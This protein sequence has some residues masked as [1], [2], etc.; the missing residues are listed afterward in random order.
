MHRELKTIAK[1]VATLRRQGRLLQKISGVNDIY[2]FFQECPKRTS[3]DFLSFYVLNYIYQYIVKDEVAKRKT[4]ARVFEDLIA[5]L[6]GGVITDELQRKNEPDTVPILLEKHSQKLSGNKREKADVSFDNFSISIKT[7]MLDNSEINLGSFERKILFEGFGVDEYLKERK[8]TNG[9]GIGL[10]SKAQIRKLLHC[11]QEKGE[12]DQFARRF[13]VMFEYVFSDDL[14]IAIKEPNK[15]SLYFV[16]SVEFINLIKNKISNIDDFLEIVNRWEGNSI[17]VDRRK[18][19][20]ECS[21]RV[22]LDLNKI[23]EL[24]S[25]MEE[26]DSML[27]YYY[28]EYTEA[29]LDHNRSQQFY[30]NKRLCEHLEWIMGRISYTFS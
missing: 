15:M 20:E 12:Y 7:L 16:E 2:E 4:S 11:I 6:F 13:V 25:L 8:A 23:Q 29:K 3:F 28:F 14:I 10:G 18:L 5:I 22:V 17:R 27:H 24:S 1:I 19:L 21:K 30:I 26:F 9:D